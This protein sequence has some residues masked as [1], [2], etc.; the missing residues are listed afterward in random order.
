[1]KEYLSKS[2][3]QKI[4]FRKSV[5]R[6]K[7]KLKEAAPLIHLLISAKSWSQ[8]TRNW[9]LRLR[10]LISSSNR[11]KNIAKSPIYLTMRIKGKTNDQWG[12]G[13]YKNERERGIRW[14]KGFSVLHM[15][16]NSC[17]LLRYLEA[18]GMEKTLA[19]R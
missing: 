2:D 3:E 17:K 16:T 14:N 15:M 18:E 4:D 6:N 5:W 9:M 1:V 13:R 12:R 7:K 10:K 8:M 11:P 19:F